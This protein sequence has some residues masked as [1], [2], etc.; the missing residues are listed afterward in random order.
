[1]P[2]LELALLGGFGGLL[3]DLINLWKYRTSQSWG[4][5]FKHIRFYAGALIGALLGAVAAYVFESTDP[6]QAIMFGYA[7]PKLF[8]SALGKVS[9]ANLQTVTD[10]KN[11]LRGVRR[12][13]GL[14]S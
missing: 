12:W 13:W 11:A 8:T 2:V 6:K 14:R 5:H 10:E 4:K 7:A 3:P 9:E 1:M